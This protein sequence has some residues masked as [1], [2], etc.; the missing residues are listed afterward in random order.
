MVWRGNYWSQW[1]LHQQL[2]GCLQRSLGHPLWA[3]ESSGNCLIPW[4]LVVGLVETL[5]V[6]LYFCRIPSLWISFSSGCW[7]CSLGSGKIHIKFRIVVTSWKE[8][9][10][11]KQVNGKEGFSPLVVSSIGWFVLELFVCFKV[12]IFWF[13]LSLFYFCMLKIIPN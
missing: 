7:F 5:R 9:R 8:G 1:L 2:L 11:W 12:R 4:G 10:Y 13:V 6:R 3:L